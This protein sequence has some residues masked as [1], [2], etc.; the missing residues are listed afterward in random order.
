M[1]RLMMMMITDGDECDDAVVNGVEV[2]S[3]LELEKAD[4]INK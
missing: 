2:H 1:N 3:V 4:L